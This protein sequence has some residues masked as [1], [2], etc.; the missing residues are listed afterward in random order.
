MPLDDLLTPLVADQIAK[1]GPGSGG[2]AAELNYSVPLPGAYSWD[3]IV[4]LDLPSD[5]FTDLARQ[6]GTSLIDLGVVTGDQGNLTGIN[7]EALAKF[8]RWAIPATARPSL[9]LVA[10][11]GGDVLPLLNAVG[12]PPT[13]SPRLA[14]TEAKGLNLLERRQYVAEPED[15]EVQRQRVDSYIDR[16]AEVVSTAPGKLSK[17]TLTLPI[18]G[19][20]S[21]IQH[22]RVDPVHQPRPRLALVE[23]WELRSYLGDYGLGRTL[24]TFSLLPGERTMIT[25][26]TWRTEAATREDATSIFDSSDSAAQSRF[27]A[28]LSTETGSASQDQGGWAL[29][30]STNASVGFNVGVVNGQFGIQAGFAANHQEASQRW[31]SQISSSAAEH[32]NQVNNSRRQAVESSSSST[33]AS[34]TSTTTV[35]EISNTNLRRVLNFV[36]REL[37]QSYDTYVVLRDI[38]VA[39]YNGNVGSAE[40]VP[41]AELGR[42]L[43]RHI[44][45]DHREETARFIL[46]MCA[47]RIDRNGDLVSCLQ[48]GSRPTGV[49]YSWQP[50]KL[51][52]DGQLDFTGNP[53]ASDVRWRF[54]RKPL[55]K[56]DRT[57]DGVIMDR[58]SI[59]LRTDSLIV[60]ALLGQADAL[61]PYGS[62]LQALDLQD[63]QS[64][65]QARAAAIERITDALELVSAQDDDKKID[66]WERLFPDNPDIQV[67]PAAA[68]T[69]DGDN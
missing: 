7:R 13:E 4:E 48:Q 68:V 37:N 35:R 47:E 51:T 22:V 27:T 66:A 62:A 26:E 3:R 9:R 20:G 30:V 39:C 55:S 49:G 61:D 1:F 46:A 16:L 33:S 36:F 64:Q 2:K 59:V 34:G 57:I 67:V 19:V 21:S 29:S 24:Q 40:I 63:R 52:S 17:A 28:A 15:V 10:E 18:A 42:L 44:E 58:S 50:A 53:L 60:E 6:S 32:A 41:L 12:Q 25:V 8:Y 11:V 54:N 45:P 56:D 69:N 14:A 38:K 43:E 5:W 23:T 31:S 65:I